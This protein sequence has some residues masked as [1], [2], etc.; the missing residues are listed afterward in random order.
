[1]AGVLSGCGRQNWCACANLACF[2]AMGLPLSWLLGLHLGHGLNG[3]W[4]GIAV[5]TLLQVRMQNSI[6][7]HPSCTAIVIPSHHRF[8]DT[9]SAHV[10]MAGNLL[11]KLWLRLLLQHAVQFR[12]TLRRGQRSTAPAQHRWVFF[13][14]V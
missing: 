4:G 11:Q 1:M 8:V 9:A 14:R 5:A 6:L 10:N 12:R 2:W 13:H 7:L 3:L